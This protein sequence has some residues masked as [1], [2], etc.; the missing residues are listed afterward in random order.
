MAV[1]PRRERYFGI[2]D[3]PAG[4]DTTVRRQNGP[5]GPPGAAQ[6]GPRAAQEPPRRAQEPPRSRPDR[7]K[8]RSG[9]PKRRSGAAHKDAPRRRRTT[10]SAGLSKISTAT[11][12]LS[13]STN[14]C[15]DKLVVLRVAALVGACVLTASGL[16]EMAVSPRRE[17]HFGISDVPA[18]RQVTVSLRRERYS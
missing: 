15:L 5:G 12:R 11:D 16:L 8:R 14:P 6:T 18:G 10:T 17:R 1:S 7:P 3:V 2:S 4:S 13:R 9:G